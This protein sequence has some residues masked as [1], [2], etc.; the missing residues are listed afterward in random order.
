[1]TTTHPP[2]PRR[3]GFKRW[4]VLGL[5]VLGAYL[6]FGAGGIFKPVSPAVVLP[7]EPVW[8]SLPS[9]PFAGQEVILPLHRSGFRLPGPVNP[10]RALRPHV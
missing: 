8:P 1:M 7:G 6:A 10:P 5:I 9:I 3:I 2:Q 4:I